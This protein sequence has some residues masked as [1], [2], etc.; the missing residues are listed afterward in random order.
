VCGQT[1]T[2]DTPDNE[3]AAV[4]AAPRSWSI[5][6]S[7]STPRGPL[8]T[9]RLLR[10]PCHIPGRQ[11]HRSLIPHVPLLHHLSQGKIG[12][13]CAILI[14]LPKLF[15]N[16]KVFTFGITESICHTFSWSTYSLIGWMPTR[17]PSLCTFLGYLKGL[18]KN[19]R[20]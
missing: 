3:E 15:S 9:R 6:S 2:T 12:S 11:G 4:T 5:R 13:S 7:R 16:N 1:Q 20:S 18:A 19:K 8:A 14:L 17:T 10:Q